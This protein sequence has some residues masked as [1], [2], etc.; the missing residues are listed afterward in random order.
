MTARSLRLLAPCKVNLT[1]DVGPRRPDGFHDLDS[2][3]ATFLPADELRVEV[4]APGDDPGVRLVCDDPRLP[5]GDANLA[6]RAAAGFLRRFAPDA[7]ARIRLHKRLPVEAGLG[8]GSSD[9][10]AVLR[11]LDVLLPGRATP[12]E[13]VEIAAALGSDVPLFLGRA[14]R[15]ARMTGRGEIL[16]SLPRPLPLL[17]GVL[18]RPE[19]GVATGPAYA[20]LDALPER[21]PGRATGRL[22][23]VL[24][25]GGDI[26]AIGAALGND[27]EPAVVPAF[28]EV[29]RAHRAVTEA[30]AVRALLCGSGSAIFGLAGDRAH[31]RALAK[32]LCGHFPWV[33][34]ARS[35]ENA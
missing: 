34:L 22:L 13:L 16:A 4:A 9:A 28:P 14:E 24:E 32:S 31:A 7:A 27:F 5:A 25:A 15:G 3:A 29:E 17:H 21:V 10:A 1:L 23:A 20:R 35:A 30:G 26:A 19:V 33:K 2:V 6:H 12:G 11:A 8:G 18:V